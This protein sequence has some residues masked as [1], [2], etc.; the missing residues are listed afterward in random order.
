MCNL[1]ELVEEK[2]IEKG[3]QDVVARLLVQGMI[4]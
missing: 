2:G 4:I 3:K 1:S